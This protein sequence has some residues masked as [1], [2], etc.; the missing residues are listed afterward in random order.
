MSIS[1]EHLR[2]KRHIKQEDGSYKLVSH[3]T[4]AETVELANGLT[5]ENSQVELTQAEYDALPEEEKMNGA[6]YFITDAESG[7]AGAVGVDITKEEYEA[8]S[9][10]EKNNGTIYFVEDESEIMGANN[11]PYDNTASGMEA[12]SVQAAIDENAANISNTNKTVETNTADIA[13]NASAITQLNSDLKPINVGS[14]AHSN[15]TNRS[16]KSGNVV[17]V[18]LFNGN[19][20]SVEK[21]KYYNLM[22]DLPV[23]DTPDE[24]VS[25][26][27]YLYYGDIN[28]TVIGSVYG[29]GTLSFVAPSTGNDGF[30]VNASY[31]CKN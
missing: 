3:W 1:N 29:S 10:E 14:S 31:I 16:K 5:L 17:V 13:A 20:I 6:E 22:T 30:A 18:D 8:L 25:I 28:Y 4:S 19:T 23:P 2:Y 26:L 27:V 12:K 21:G 7:E 24:I 15:A 11:I 9:E